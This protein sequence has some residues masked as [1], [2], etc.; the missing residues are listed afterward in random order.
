[1]KP[2]QHGLPETSRGATAGSQNFHR[3]RTACKARQPKNA[4]T[5]TT[6]PIRIRR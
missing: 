5:P 2:F 3:A 6:A 1:M 4:T